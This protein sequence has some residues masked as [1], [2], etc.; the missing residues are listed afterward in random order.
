MFVFG[1][2][3]LLIGS[4]LDL[5]AVIVP[6]LIGIVALAVGVEGYWRDPLGWPERLLLVGA[7]L[8]LVKPGLATDALGVGLVLAAALVHRLRRRPVRL[9]AAG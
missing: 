1:P 4:P 6:A 3:L 5:V 9:G 7:S 2:G 8:S